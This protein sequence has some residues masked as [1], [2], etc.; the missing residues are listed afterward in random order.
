MSAARR[1]GAWTEERGERSERDEGRRRT[2]APREAN[3]EMR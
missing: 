1:R 3:R 2:E